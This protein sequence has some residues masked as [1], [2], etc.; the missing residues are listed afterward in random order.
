MKIKWTA[1]VFNLLIWLALEITLTFL[2]FDDLADYGEFI[3]ENKKSYFS[4][5]AE[6]NF[7]GNIPSSLHLS[8]NLP[9]IVNF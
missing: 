4:L 7:T 9:E 1:L 6:P 3:L 2:G 8:P 5:L